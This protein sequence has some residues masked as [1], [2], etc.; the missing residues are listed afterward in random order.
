MPLLNFKFN[1]NHY[2]WNVYVFWKETVMIRKIKYIMSQK[3]SSSWN[4]CTLHKR[5][6][7]NKNIFSCPLYLDCSLLVEY[8]SK[9]SIIQKLE[10]HRK[11]ILWLKLLPKFSKKFICY[12]NCSQTVDNLHRKHPSSESQNSHPKGRTMEV[13]AISHRLQ[14]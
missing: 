10:A 8:L 12:L 5:I 6:N 14:L 3:K 9:N 11:Y 13:F 2:L 4:Y 7:S 1:V